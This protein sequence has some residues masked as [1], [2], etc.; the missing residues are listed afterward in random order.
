MILVLRIYYQWVRVAACQLPLA[1]TTMRVI[2]MNH[3]IL[4]CYFHSSY[5]NAWYKCCSFFTGFVEFTCFK[6]FG[7]VKTWLEL[8]DKLMPNGR[9]MVNCGGTND[10]VP[11]TTDIVTSPGLSSFQSTCEQVSTLKALSKAFPGQ[12]GTFIQYLF[13]EVDYMLLHFISF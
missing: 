13:G 12:V 10:G 3:S 2:L 8:N 6:S 11:S 9:L 1:A 5:A 4:S 7:Q